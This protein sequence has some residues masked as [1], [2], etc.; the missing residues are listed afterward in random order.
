MCTPATGTLSGSGQLLQL[1][2]GA[3]FWASIAI[4]ASQMAH[5]WLMLMIGGAYATMS[6]GGHGPGD[7]HDHGHE[8]SSG[9]SQADLLD[10]LPSLPVCIQGNW[11]LFKTQMLANMASPTHSS[12]AMTF[13]PYASYTFYMPNSYPGM[14]MA[15]QGGGD[16]SDSDGHDHDHG[17]R[18]SRHMAPCPASSIDA[19]GVLELPQT[20]FCAD[21]DYPTYKTS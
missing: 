2:E 17:R 16:H 15:P 19:T 12:H 18:L 9:E 6:M 8:A 7:G 20:A 3:L 21:G 10:A 4:A 5:T 1:G 11:P 14:V 13:P